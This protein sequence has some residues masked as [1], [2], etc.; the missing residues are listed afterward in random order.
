MFVR[1]FFFIVIFWLVI[2]VFWGFGWMFCCCWMFRC[3][4]CNWRFKYWSCWS[5]CWI[6]GGILSCWRFWL[7]VNICIF[8]CFIVFKFEFC[9]FCMGKEFER[10]IGGW[11]VVFGKVWDIFGVEVVICFCVDIIIEVVLF[12][13][14]VIFVGRGL[15][16]FRRLIKFVLELNIGSLRF[17]RVFFML[18]I[19]MF[20]I[21]IVFLELLLLLF[22]EL[23][24][25]SLIFFG[26]EGNI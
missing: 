6:F 8:N 15:V 12:E 18:M 14:G 17:F 16:F 21:L 20:L 13:F 25:L 9:V 7:F 1:D 22:L 3:F 23:F 11:V 5:C 2:G 4:S 10:C 19:R 26:M 24:V